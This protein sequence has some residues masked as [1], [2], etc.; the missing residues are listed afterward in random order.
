MRRAAT[1]RQRSDQQAEYQADGHVRLH[2][3]SGV[4]QVVQRGGSPARH[5]EP[6]AGSAALDQAPMLLTSNYSR[7]AQRPPPLPALPGEASRG[8]RGS[9]SQ[10]RHGGAMIT[11]ARHPQAP[12]ASHVSAGERCGGAQT[13]REGHATREP[14]SG[15]GGRT[16]AGAAHPTRSRRASE[17]RATRQSAPFRL[18]VATPV[19]GGYV[20]MPGG[21]RSSSSRGGCDRTSG[22]RASDGPIPLHL[23]GFRW[24]PDVTEA[25]LLVDDR[26]RR[27]SQGPSSYGEPC[28]RGPSSGGA[29]GLR[30]R[31]RSALSSTPP[32]QASLRDAADRA[33]RGR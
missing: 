2:I 5:A 15:G 4:L 23:L 31:R 27:E 21:R 28:A 20:P 19:R 32:R 29:C 24:L 26:V 9:R 6:T 18:A 33:R 11:A 13:R 17:S 25:H 1:A 10:P 22:S 12:V 3:P 8:C 7:P 16:H 30:S 14:A